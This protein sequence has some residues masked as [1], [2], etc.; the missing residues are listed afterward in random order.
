MARDLGNDPVGDYLR[1]IKV[2]I[3][4]LKNKQFIGSDN[5]QL[6]LMQ[7]TAS[8]DVS[9]TIPSSFTPK[10]IQLNYVSTNQPYPFFYAMGTLYYDSVSPANIEER[11]DAFNITDDV[12]FGSPY[13]ATFNYEIINTYGFTRTFYLKFYLRA[14]DPVTTLSFTILP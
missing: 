2:D 5:L 14:S 3:E 8:Y 9:V 12:L 6:Y 13:H 10:I 1:E 7:S 4:E 11:P